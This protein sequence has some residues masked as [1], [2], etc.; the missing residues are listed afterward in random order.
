MKN[1]QIGL[2]ILILVAL[3]IGA[4]SFFVTELTNEVTVNGYLGGEKIGFFENERLADYLYINH[5]I[6]LDYKKAGS[7]DMV[8]S[9]TEGLDY[10]FPSSQL[11]LEIFKEEGGQAAGSEII[12]N[13]PIVLYTRQLVVDALIK[14]GLVEDRNGVYYIQMPKL[15]QLIAEGKTWQDLGLGELYGQVSIKTTDPNKSNSGNMFLG[16]LANALNQNQVATEADLDRIRPQLQKIYQAAGHMQS[17][18]A[19]LWN[20]FL[21]MGVG[22]YPI[23]AGYESQILELSV[24]EPETFQ[25]LKEDPSRGIRLLYPEPTVYSTHPFI[26]LNENGL[27]TMEALLEEEPQQIAWEDH[28]YRTSIAGAEVKTFDVQGLAPEI[29][30]VM[31][32]P[33][34]RVMEDLMQTVTTP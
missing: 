2:T 21:R 25:A 9:D 32:L 5:S 14:E 26:A 19:D 33:S 4:Y 18:S 10:L 1:K 17:S 11:A 16:L 15:A 7:I 29:T 34:N 30:Q 27:A 28:G 23:I 6:I 22:S 8:R 31:P 20:Q 3:G 24:A 12:F 13:T